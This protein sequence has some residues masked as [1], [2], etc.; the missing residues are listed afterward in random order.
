MMGGIR[1]A[2][3]PSL[4]GE[5]GPLLGEGGHQGEG[6]PLLG[7]EGHLGSEGADNRGRLLSLTP[8]QVSFYIRGP[9]LYHRLLWRQSYHCALQR[10]WAYQG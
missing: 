9:A 4:M 7:E 10:G 8:Q 3:S 1:D 2:G 5:E 6:G